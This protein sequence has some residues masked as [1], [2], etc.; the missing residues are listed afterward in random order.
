MYYKFNY[1]HDP[2]VTSIIISFYEKPDI[3]ELNIGWGTR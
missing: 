2:V 3:R 1:T